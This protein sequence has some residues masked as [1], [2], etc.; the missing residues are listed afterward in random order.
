MPQS[1]RNAR[2]TEIRSS[3]F[4]L[5]YEPTANTMASSN[6]ETKETIEKKWNLQ[7]V[8]KASNTAASRQNFTINAGG[9][10]FHGLSSNASDFSKTKLANNDTSNS[11]ELRFQLA[12]RLK[13]SN[14]P[15]GDGY[16]F[17][18]SNND[19]YL[20]SNPAD[21]SNKAEALNERNK[22][23]EKVRGAK[24]N[25]IYG[26][27]K[28][29]YNSINNTTFMSPEISNYVKSDEVKLQALEQRKHNFKT[30][31]D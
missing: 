10:V 13:Q 7:P 2:V 12:K 31:Y 4:T 1:I 29:T 9:A 22:I 8:T 16:T 23:V 11:E 5:G 21:S 19:A 27:D 26:Q 17:N 20:P 6:T 30:S 18:T 3:H 15:F 25:F 28:P 14:L 24:P